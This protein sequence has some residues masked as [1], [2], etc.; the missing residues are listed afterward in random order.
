MDA[1]D[2]KLNQY[3]NDMNNAAKDV[4]I[5]DRHFQKFLLFDPDIN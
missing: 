1:F 4:S 3:S 5:I 2:R